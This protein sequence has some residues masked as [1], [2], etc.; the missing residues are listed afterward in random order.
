MK[1]QDFG[2]KRTCTVIMKKKTFKTE[3][4]SFEVTR[5]PRKI[6]QGKYLRL[7]PLQNY[8]SHKVGLDV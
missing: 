7:S 2:K 6:P 4:S 1:Q 5:K 3:F 8:F